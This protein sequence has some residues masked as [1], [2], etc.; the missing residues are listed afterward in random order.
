MLFVTGDTHGLED[1]DKLNKFAG[2]HSKLTRSD[3]VIIAGDFGAVWS[4]STLT[5]KLHHYV[6][7]P[8]T[9][10]FVDGN[11]ENFDLLA[12]YPVTEWN[13]GK[14][15]VIKPNVIHLMRGQVYDIEGK[16][17]FTF[18]G[19]TSIDKEMRREG[20]SW[21]RQEQPTFDEL[22]EGLANL[23][24]YDNKV[25]YIVTHSCGQRAMESLK[26]IFSVGDKAT[27]SEVN[28]L[29]NFEDVASFKHWYFG[30]F[31]ADKKLSYKYTVIYNNI[32]RLD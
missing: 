25:D 13:G 30:H 26:R 11:H 20:I 12:T 22:D 4:E 29:S 16:T 5:E 15:Q 1:F 24:R 31:H 18:G 2:E 32:E 21:W 6:E 19:A 17:I 7:L 27:A 3:Y 9:V 8:F 28:L 23:K 14:A 10:L